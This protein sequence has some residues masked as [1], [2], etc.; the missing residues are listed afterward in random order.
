M[1]T[2]SMPTARSDIMTAYAMTDED[3]KLV[4]ITVREWNTLPFFYFQEE[5]PAPRASARPV[6]E[7]R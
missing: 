7:I 5:G 2:A 1:P 6:D 3:T 4:K